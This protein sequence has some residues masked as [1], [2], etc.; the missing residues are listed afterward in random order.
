MLSKK[1]NKASNQQLSKFFHLVQTC[2]PWFPEQGTLDLDSCN[3]VGKK[4]KLYYTLHGPENVP[5]DAFSLW[6]LLREMLDP[7]H[8]TVSLHKK[9]KSQLCIADPPIPSA[10][11][12]RTPLLHSKKTSLVDE[13]HKQ[14]GKDKLSPS[15]KED[16]EEAA[17]RCYSKNDD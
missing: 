10:P 15:E 17:A 8:E 9:V 16:L 4:L 3:K 5:V 11:S 7:G 2:C 1:G 13:V 12:E 6:N 14:S